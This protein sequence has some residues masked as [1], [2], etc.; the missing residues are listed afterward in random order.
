MNKKNLKITLLRGPLVF[1][2]DGVNNEATTAIGLAYVD[3]YLRQ[4]GYET[5]WVDAIAEGLNQTW[6]LD[7]F[8]GF[9]CQ[10]LTFDE[11][12]NRIPKST[13]AIG[14]SGM[15]SGEWPIYR[16][17]INRIKEHFPDVFIVGGGEHFTALPEY[18]LRDCLAL[19]VCVL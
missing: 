13:E 8:P 9:N 3:G 7:K 17:L 19:D 4:G 16:E 18:C 11:I 14:F 6:A 5:T 12:L 10:G 2:D 1:R 15:F